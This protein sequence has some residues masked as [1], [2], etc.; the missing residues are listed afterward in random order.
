MKHILI[1][2]NVIFL[3][4]STTAIIADENN[5]VFPASLNLTLDEGETA[6]E[7]VSLTIHPYCIRP[8]YVDVIASDPNVSITNLTGVVINGCGGDTSSFDIEFSGSLSPQYFDLQ[9]VDSEYGGVLATIP[10]SISPEQNLESLLGVL[11]NESSIVFQVASSGCTQKRDF[12]VEVMESLPL[13]LR[14]IRIN[15]DPCDAY[16]PLG[17]RINFKYNELGIAPGDALRV[18]NPLGTVVVPY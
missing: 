13:Q 8:F 18:V 1:L 12:R 5:T 10:V 3:L 17:T 15:P 2:W 7:Q 4:C 6:I 9:F 14:L 16:V 11:F